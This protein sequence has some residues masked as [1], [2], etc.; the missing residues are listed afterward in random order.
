MNIELSK[1]ELE[2]IKRGLS[3]HISD[4]FIGDEDKPYIDL[5]NKLE[6]IDDY[7]GELKK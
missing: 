2:M 1:A 5:L 3:D 6:K 4:C 7:N